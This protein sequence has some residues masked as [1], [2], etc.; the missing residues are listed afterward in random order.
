MIGQKKAVKEF[1]F[2]LWIRKQ[3]S[4]LL[5]FSATLKCANNVSVVCKHWQLKANKLI[6]W[7]SSSKKKKLGPPK[8]SKLP[9]FKGTAWWQF[10][11]LWFLFSNSFH[12]SFKWFCTCSI[13]GTTNCTEEWLCTPLSSTSTPRRG[14]SV[15]KAVPPLL[16]PM[17]LYYALALRE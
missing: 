15:F 13:T 7:V 1:A 12:C 5:F 14:K 3:Y 4:Y 10:S 9:L 2:W 8:I 17:V 16:L 11:L 6:P